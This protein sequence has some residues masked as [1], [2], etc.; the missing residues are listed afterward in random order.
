MNSEAWYWSP[1]SASTE[2]SNETPGAFPLLPY[3]A[4]RGGIE[5]NALSGMVEIPLPFEKPQVMLQA[6]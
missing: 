2:A 1:P 6:K 3:V 5:V 4:L